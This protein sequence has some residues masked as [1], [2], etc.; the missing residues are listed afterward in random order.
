M[1]RFSDEV[2]LQGYACEL[3]AHIVHGHNEASETFATLGGIDIVLSA[4][5]RFSDEVS[6]QC[7][8]CQLLANLAALQ[9]VSAHIVEHPDGIPSIIEAMKKFPDHAFLQGSGCCALRNLSSHGVQ[10]HNDK[11]VQ[12]GGLVAL[13]EAKTKHPNK[14]E[15][16]WKHA[17]KAITNLND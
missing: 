3:L 10:E 2:S 13:E 7:H 9:S 4:M 16:L 8:A 11:I 5:K 15:A 14:N 12:A 6:L 1:K 17:R